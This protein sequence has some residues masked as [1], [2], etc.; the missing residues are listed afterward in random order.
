MGIS[1]GEVA[2]AS[3]ALKL[4]PLAKIQHFSRFLNAATASVDY[5][6]FGFKPKALTVNVGE[7]TG[8]FFSWGMY[9]SAQTCM[10]FAPSGEVVIFTSGKI[11]NIQQQQAS[12]GATASDGFTLAWTLV[13]SGTLASADFAVMAIGDGL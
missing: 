6:G 7:T 11:I 1:T 12:V 3:D 5:T 4:A 2:T 13:A 10:S 9:A 8:G